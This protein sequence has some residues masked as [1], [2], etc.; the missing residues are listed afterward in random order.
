MP[1]NFPLEE[2]KFE[3]TQT[4][5]FA[6]SDNRNKLWYCMKYENNQFKTGQVILEHNKWKNAQ[7]LPATLTYWREYPRSP[8]FSV[9]KDF[10]IE[11]NDNFESILLC[12]IAQQVTRIDVFTFSNTNKADEQVSKNKT[13]TCHLARRGKLGFEFSYGATGG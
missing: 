1:L 11:S 2:S 5:P 10:I 7:L 6:V 3:S 9:S 13:H 12:S 4:T 8:S